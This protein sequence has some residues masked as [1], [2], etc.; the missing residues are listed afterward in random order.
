MHEARW[1]LTQRAVRASSSKIANTSSLLVGI[2]RRV[3]NSSGFVGKLLLS[4]ANTS[5]A[6]SVGA[7]RALAGN[8]FVVREA[9][10]LSGL[11]VAKTLV[12]ALND[13]MGIVSILNIT[14]PSNRSKQAINT[15]DY[16]KQKQLVES[17]IRTLGKFFQS[18]LG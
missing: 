15:N 7:D 17:L 4:K 11:A 1:Q 2:P 18:S 8:S 10:A 12:R 14:N 16:H 5:I 3:V 9:L 13:R 6:A